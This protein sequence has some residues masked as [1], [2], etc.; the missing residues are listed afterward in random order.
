MLLAMR[1]LAMFLLLAVSAQAQ[2]VLGEMG[3]QVAGLQGTAG[4]FCRGFT[5]VPRQLNVTSG[6]TL[7][8]TVRAPLGAPFVV[9]A[10][11]SATSCL[12]IPTIGNSLV[13]DLPLIVLYSGSID[14]PSPI[15]ACYDG[16]TTRSL[17]LP[18]GLPLGAA[19]AMQAGAVI[20]TPQY[21]STGFGL[22]SAVLAI[23][24]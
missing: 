1:N 18:G 23:V 2:I 5:C 3:F 8:L 9:A 13:I 15:L 11:A 16:Y 21:P 14:K 19:L 24:R 17:P 10:S 20:G 4:D 7:T 22:A 12:K 6:E